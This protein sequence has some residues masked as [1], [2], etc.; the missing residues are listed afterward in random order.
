MRH[1]ITRNANETKKF[2]ARLA[3]SVRPPK[4]IALEGDL[5]AGKTTFTQGFARAL[6]IKERIQSP[7]F[8][9]MKV[10][11]ISQTSLRGASATKQSPRLSR[12]ARSGARNDGT[13]GFGHLI[14]IDCCRLGPPKDLAH[15]GFKNLLKDKD[16]IILIEWADRIRK[17]LPRRTL[18]IKFKHGK[19]PHERMIL[20]SN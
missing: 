14:H 10:Y 18:R 12:P 17:L 11:D 7:T 15:L 4:V 3:R 8:V 9:L 20:I 2:A 19:N 1:F 16:A 13:R 6:G 5:G